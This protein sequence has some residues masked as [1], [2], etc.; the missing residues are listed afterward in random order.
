MRVNKTGVASAPADTTIDFEGETIPARRGETIAAALVAAGH[1]AFRRTAKTGDRGL[2]CGMGVCS[3]CAVQIGAEAGRLAC[4]EKV[5]PGLCVARNPAARR[6]GAGALPGTVPPAPPEEN[7]DCDLLVVGAGPA[8]LRA[9]VAAARAGVKVAVVDE[10]PE[11][12]GQFLKQPAGSLEIDE[13]ALDEQYRLGRV[14]LREASESGVELLSG[15]RVWGGTGRG[16]L[17]AASMSHRFVLRSRALVLA[18]GAFERVVPFPGWTLPGVITT[19]AAQTLLR[20]YLVAAGARV[21]VA[22]N[23]PL[24]IQVAAELAAAGVSVVAV[25]E[26]APLFRPPNALHLAMMSAAAPHDAGRGF[27]YLHTLA[28]ARVPVLSRSTVVAVTGNGRA[29]VA[30]VARLDREGRP[31]PGRPGISRWTRCALVSA[32]PPRANWPAPWD[33]RTGWTSRREPSGSCVTAMGGPR[34]QASGWRAMAAGSAVLEWP[35]L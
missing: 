22:G 2:F 31:E 28:R 30:T 11:A 7:I 16:E 5:A 32:L 1:Y 24:N 15:V 19:G 29:E 23:G 17:Y 12:G 33:V 20:S 4:M 3:E 26:A 14:L 34:S 8:G 6:L 27:S 9:A 35:R 21:L 10:R 25:A 13:Q 18:T